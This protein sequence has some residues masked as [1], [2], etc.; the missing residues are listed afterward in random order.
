MIHIAS[1][2]IK[3]LHKSRYFIYAW[4]DFDVFFVL[5][6]VYHFKDFVTMCVESNLPSFK[7]LGISLVLSLESDLSSTRFCLLLANDDFLI[8]WEEGG[9]RERETSEHILKCVYDF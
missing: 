5:S 3:H 1:P 4:D 6:C 8:Q 2:L 7:P 9:S